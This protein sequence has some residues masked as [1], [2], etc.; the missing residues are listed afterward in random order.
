MR[1]HVSD[2]I[3]QQFQ[4]ELAALDRKPAEPLNSEELAMLTPAQRLAL[5]KTEF[6][7]LQRKHRLHL[8]DVLTFFPEEEVVSFLQSLMN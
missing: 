8:D 6:R 2:D 4:Q 5:A 1:K 3:W 7:D